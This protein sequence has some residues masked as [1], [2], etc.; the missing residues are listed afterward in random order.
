MRC[1][2][3]GRKSMC[4]SKSAQIF[5]SHWR[6]QNLRCSELPS[7]PRPSQG[8]PAPPWLDRA[9][10]RKACNRLRRS[11]FIDDVL[12]NAKKMG[13]LPLKMV[14]S[15]D[16]LKPLTPVFFGSWRKSLHRICNKVAPGSCPIGG[17]ASKALPRKRHICRDEQSVSWRANWH[18]Y[19][20][21]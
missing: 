5:C 11:V 15:I 21:S 2:G 19:R 16:L 18:S 14:M 4:R 20:R 6:V 3:F 13:A 1:C 12:R 7:S 17:V 8:R 10:Q 9:F